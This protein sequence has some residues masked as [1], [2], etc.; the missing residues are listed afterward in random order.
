MKRERLLANGCSLML[1]VLAATY[2]VVQ[3]VRARRL[4]GVKRAVEFDGGETIL[5]SV[6]NFALELDAHFRRLIGHFFPDK[7]L[8]THK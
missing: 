4:K 6:L 2:P 3:E 8:A 5:G 1:L 7:D